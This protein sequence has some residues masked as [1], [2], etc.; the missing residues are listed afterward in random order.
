MTGHFDLQE[1]AIDGLEEHFE[2]LS[3]DYI[4][5]DDLQQ[6]RSNVERDLYTEPKEYFHNWLDEY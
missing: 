2:E 1:L 5:T 4:D 3:H 6:M